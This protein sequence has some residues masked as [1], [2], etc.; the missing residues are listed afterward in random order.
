[1]TQTEPLR[2]RLRYTKLGRVAYLGH[3]DLIRH[4][5]RIFRRAGVDL[6]YSSGFHPKPELS[7]GPALGLG[8]PSIGEILDVKMTDAIDPQA[9]LAELRAVTLEGIDLL[10]AVALGDNDKALGRVLSVAEYAALLPPD[11]S[12]TGAIE[13][14]ASGEALSLVREGSSEGGRAKIGRRIDV[15]RTLLE[16]TGAGEAAGRLG[17]AFAWPADRI[18]RFRLA[19]SAE[20]GARPAEVLDALLGPE[21]GAASELVRVN[22]WARALGSDVVIDPLDLPPL[23]G[24]LQL[25]LEPL[26]G[27]E[28]DSGAARHLSAAPTTDAAAPVHSPA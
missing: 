2:Y 6:Y 4:L 7:F 14:F 11:A 13:R 3:L 12:L 15:R 9:L 25:G 10:G 16:V 26:A 19:V 28:G 8:I 22:L 20:G 23:R 24:R 1:M 27:T 5:P 17:D 18:V 21:L